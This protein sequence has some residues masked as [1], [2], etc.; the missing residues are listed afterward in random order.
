VT[1][2]TWPTNLVPSSSEWRFIAN[3]AAFT[4]PLS[5]ATRTLGRGGDRWAC[6]LQF[7]ALIG[8][9]RSEMQGFIAR[10]RGQANRVILPDHSYKRRG[11]LAANI[12][13]KGSSQT[14]LTL[15]CDGGTAGV[16]N[17]LRTGDYV[18][19]ENYPYM[20]VLDASTN[21]SGEVTLTLNRPLVQ[22]PAD[23][24]A[25][26]LLTPTGKFLLTDNTVGWSNTPAGWPRIVSSFTLDFIED[27]A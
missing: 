19:V 17:A 12:L 4:S 18:T 2:F 20:V 3:T 15:A 14:G 24:A 23:N 1:D 6:T 26:N 25:V 11:A 8:D 10:L 16:T 9:A 22:S 5:G 27:I 7:N 13:V 21:G